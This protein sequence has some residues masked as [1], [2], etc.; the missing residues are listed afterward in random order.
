MFIVV[1]VVLEVAFAPTSLH[2]PA[3]VLIAAVVAFAAGRALL[4]RGAS[5]FGALL[6]GALAFVST[7]V[8][9]VITITTLFLAACGSNCF[10]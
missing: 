10:D 7:G 4:E 3:A 6:G 5:T 9:A 2:L 1:A 8:I